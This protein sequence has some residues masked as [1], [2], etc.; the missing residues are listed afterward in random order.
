MMPVAGKPIIARVVEMLAEGGVDHFIVVAH[1]GDL[2]LLT[3]LARSPWA[4]RCRL[5]Y[6]EQRLGMADAVACAAPLVQ[7]E[8]ADEFVLASCDSL[9][10]VDHVAALVARRRREELD[11]AITLMWT[12]PEKAT[13]S[14]VV[15]VR[16]GAVADIIEKPE[17]AEIP[18]YSGGRH[19]ALSAP[20]LYALSTRVL[21]YVDQVGQS[22]R[23]E[24]EFPD[25]LRLLI[26]EGGRVRGQLVESRKTLTRPRDLLSLNLEALQS[27]PSCATVA[28]AI[29][30]DATLIPPVRIEEKVSV[31]PGCSIGPQ[32]Y[33]E[34]GCHVGSGA[35]IQRSVVMRG[36]RV[37]PN[38]SIRESVIC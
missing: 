18:S 29:P 28:S 9:Y 27:D 38:R 2:G 17:L 36:A 31:A 5:A 25:A 23:G 19:E 1:P 24:R 26:S 34:T 14:A 35:V 7:Q 16:D 3:Y 30:A 22:S 32:A 4:A 21:E 37:E 33:L 15:V 13:A 12:P 11:A 6:Q 8:D 20:S 10:P